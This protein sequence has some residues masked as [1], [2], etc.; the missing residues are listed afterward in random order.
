[1]T[2][3]VLAFDGL[4]VD[5]LN[6]RAESLLLALSDERIDVAPE[7][8]REVLPG[9]TFEEA[10]DALVGDSDPTVAELVALRAQREVS[11][12]LARGVSLAMHAHAFVEA[13]RAMGA[14]LV[15]RT[16]S[17][18]RDVESL[19]R[20]FRRLG[21]RRDAGALWSVV[22]ADIPKRLQ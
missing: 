1:M 5:T 16:D 8:V 18:R 21:V 12:R 19:C 17:L 22:A 4:I 9:R 2:A 15:L 7:R 11:M 13:Q 6:A 14:K 10:V 20:S 3:V